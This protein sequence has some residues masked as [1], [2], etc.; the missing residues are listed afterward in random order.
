ML[1][2]CA[3]SP[4]GG[5]AVDDGLDLLCDAEMLE[6]V[7]RAAGGDEQ[8]FRFTQTLVQEV[9]YQNLLLKRRNELHGEVGRVLEELYGGKPSA[10]RRSRRWATTSV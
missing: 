3:A 2:C 1:V 6:E 7:P 8:L 9:V 10:S 4:A 5:P